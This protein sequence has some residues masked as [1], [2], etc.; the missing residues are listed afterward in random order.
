MRHVVM[1][2]GGASSA[3]VAVRVVERYGPADVVLLFAD[4]RHGNRRRP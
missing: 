3:L 1:L 2:S 4:T